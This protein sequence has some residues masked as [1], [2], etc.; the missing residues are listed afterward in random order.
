[1]NV[2]CGTCAAACVILLLRS[3]SLSFTSSA[4]WKALLALGS[5]PAQGSSAPHG[6]APSGGHRSPAQRSGVQESTR[7]LPHTWRTEHY[8]FTCWKTNT[9]AQ[10]I[11]CNLSHLVCGGRQIRPGCQILLEFIQVSGVSRLHV[12]QVTQ[13]VFSKAL[14]LLQRVFSSVGS[15]D[16][17]RRLFVRLLNGVEGAWEWEV[18]H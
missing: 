17:V 7:S 2:C 5:A 14:R 16:G 13:G 11:M 1:M 4:S 15:L 9:S 3:C 12:S 6:G 18:F 10:P 8:W